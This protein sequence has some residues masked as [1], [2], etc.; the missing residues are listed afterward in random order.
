MWQSRAAYLMVTKIF[1]YIERG[2][3]ERRSEGEE[4]IGGTYG[5]DRSLKVILS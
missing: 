5:Q 3:R 1:T 2:E 4:K